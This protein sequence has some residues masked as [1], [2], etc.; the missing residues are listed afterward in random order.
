[1][2]SLIQASNEQL[3]ALQLAAEQNRQ[4]AAAGI[5][6]PAPDFVPDLLESEE[7][8]AEL[9]QEEQPLPRG[10]SPRKSQAPNKLLLRKSPKSPPRLWSAI[11]P[12]L[13][14]LR[15]HR[16]PLWIV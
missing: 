10:T 7:T 4:Q 13:F 16:R 3:R 15:R 12:A 9:A 2:E 14:A 1:M 11:Q 8:D 5:E 6:Q